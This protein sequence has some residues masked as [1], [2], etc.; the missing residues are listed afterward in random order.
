MKRKLLPYLL[1]LVALFGFTG[2]FELEEKAH[3]NRDGSGTYQFTV[4]LGRLKSFIDMMDAMSEESEDA[5]SSPKEEIKDGFN[6][7]NEKLSRIRGISNIKPIEDE[8][9]F[10]FGLSFDFK[11]IDALNKAMNATFDIK[12][13]GEPV[14]LDFFSFKNGRLERFEYQNL[15]E[16]LKDAKDGEEI[17]LSGGSFMDDFTYTTIYTFEKPVQNVSNQ[18][19]MLSPDRKTVTHS[20]HPFREG[21]TTT[22]HNIIEF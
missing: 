2:C 7:T 13:D 6:E 18:T 3:F 20:I 1:S 4:D 17:D 22:L 16:A 5:K 11:D 14:D 12:K 21:D 8:E 15:E 19:V 9:N 10:H